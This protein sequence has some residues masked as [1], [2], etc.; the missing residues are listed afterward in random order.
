MVFLA[1][2]A[3][4]GGIQLVPDG[5]M[6]LHIVMILVM[7]WILNR[8]FF[9]PINKIIES[10]VKNQG[11]RY[12]EAEEILQK[13]DS[14]SAEFEAAML[15]ARSEGYELIEKERSKA[16]AKR[17]KKM[18]AVKEEVA[19]KSAAE[20]EDLEKQTA[21]AKSEIAT[22]AEKMAEQISSNILK[23]A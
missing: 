11:G 20:F 1:F 10:R 14:K 8:T 6:L 15:E 21:A 4:G 19:Q 13:V 3:E 5:T 16:V 9:R 18:S 22:E 7:I 2:A 12:T 23:A 17:E